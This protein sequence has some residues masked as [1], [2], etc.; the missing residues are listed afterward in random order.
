M[1]VEN[2]AQVQI[3][4]HDGRGCLWLAAGRGHLEVCKW[5][6]E[7]KEMPINYCGKMVET[8]YAVALR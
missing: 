2:G 7:D 4:A 1:L 3:Y 5:L 8:T 6:V